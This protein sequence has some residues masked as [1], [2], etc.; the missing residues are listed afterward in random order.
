MTLSQKLL[1]V[2]L[3]VKDWIS[4]EPVM[5]R[6]LLVAL[7][8]LLARFGV[9]LDWEYVGGIVLALGSLATRG[10]RG[11]VMTVDKA[12]RMARRAAAATST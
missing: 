1:G 4:R 6:F 10:A 8:G 7:T 12:E 11:K 2:Y 3:Y 9:E 5:A